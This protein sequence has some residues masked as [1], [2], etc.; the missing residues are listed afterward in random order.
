MQDVQRFLPLSKVRWY[1]YIVSSLG[2]EADTSAFAVVSN[3][4]FS[5]SSLTD[6]VVHQHYYPFHEKD[7]SPG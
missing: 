6:K 5:S 7:M 1:S 3:S 4:S 2:K